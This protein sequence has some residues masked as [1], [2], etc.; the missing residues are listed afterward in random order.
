MLLYMCLAKAE[1][2]LYFRVNV[3]LRA[4]VNIDLHTNPSP[5]YYA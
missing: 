1:L 4:V 3:C 5:H 2:S